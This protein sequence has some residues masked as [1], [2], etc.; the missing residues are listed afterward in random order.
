MASGLLL[1][2][3]LPLAKP[4]L[5]R[6]LQKCHHLWMKCTIEGIYTFHTFHIY[7]W[8]IG[9]MYVIHME[10]SIHVKIIIYTHIYEHIVFSYI[11][12]IETF[13]REGLM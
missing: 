4:H 6:P 1:S 11:T 2:D 8:N 3:T 5:L 9:K 12:A 10:T 7:M 13:I